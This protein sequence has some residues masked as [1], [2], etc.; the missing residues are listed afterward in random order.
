MAEIVGQDRQEPFGILSATVPIQ[1]RLKSKSVTEIV[2]AR[3]VVIGGAAQANLMGQGVECVVDGTDIQSLAAAG[4]KKIRRDR[5]S[6][7]KSVAA[8]HVIGKH[9][10]CGS[11]QRHEPGLSKLAA[12]NR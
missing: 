3:A 7:C 12:F 9:I 11:V 6:R 2:E 10:A 1:Q 4:N 8:R 5:P